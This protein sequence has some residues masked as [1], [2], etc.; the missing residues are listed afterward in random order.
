MGV[1]S[2]NSSYPVIFVFL[3][4]SLAKMFASAGAISFTLSFS[5]WIGLFPTLLALFQCPKFF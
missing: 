4:H 1:M 2:A 5:A 3:D